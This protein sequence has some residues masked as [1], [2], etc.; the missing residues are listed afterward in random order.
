MKESLR[1]LLNPLHVYCRLKECGLP[2]APALSLCA[3][4]GRLYARLF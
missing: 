2:S 1:H 3:L 4:Y